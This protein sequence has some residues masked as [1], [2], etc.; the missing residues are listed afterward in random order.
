MALFAV[1]SLQAVIFHF[2]QQKNSSGYAQNSNTHAKSDY[3]LDISLITVLTS[4]VTEMQK[5]TQKIFE[6]VFLK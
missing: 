2:C 1:E 3:Y 5:K 4:M 6:N